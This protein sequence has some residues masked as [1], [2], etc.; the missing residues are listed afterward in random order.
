MAI[1][2]TSSARR[3][4]KYRHAGAG[5]TFAAPFM[6]VF[7]AMFLAPLGYALYLSLFR[8]QIIGGSVFVGIDNYTQA[9]QDSQFL[10]GLG[11]II[12]FFFIQVPIMLVLA[13]LFALMLDSGKVRGSKIFR[14]VFFVPYAV[15]AVVAALMWGY[16]YGAKFG[17]FTQLANDLGVAPPHFLTASHLLPSIANVVTWEF[18]GYNMI[19]LYAALRA[20]PTDLYEAAAI[21]GAGPVRTALFIKLPLLLPALGVILLFSVIGAFQLFNEPKVLQPAAGSV[22]TPNWTPNLY[23]YNLAFT[24]QQLNYAAAVSFLLGFIILLATYT[25]MG[26]GRLRRSS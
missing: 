11:R 6:V 26:L 13:T 12:I 7:A 10:S 8:N 20:I 2:T 23:A 1:S 22:I 18:A 24:D 16:L 15:P 5:L 3:S 17:P 25:A 19:I 14:I 4:H 21:D 9:L